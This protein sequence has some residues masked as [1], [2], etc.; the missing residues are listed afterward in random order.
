MLRQVVSHIRLY[1]SDCAQWALP[2]AVLVSVLACV[3]RV[4]TCKKSGKSV[5]TLS[6]F[7]YGFA[8]GYYAAFLL[9]VTW[10]MRIPGSHREVPMLPFHILIKQYDWNIYRCKN[11]TCFI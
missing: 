10:L 11:C 1:N 2:T 7:G 9:Y 4:K 8:T 5:G 3:C 6:L